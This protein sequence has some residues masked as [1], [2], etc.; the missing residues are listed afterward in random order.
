MWRWLLKRLCVACVVTSLLE[1]CLRCCV[2]QW[3]AKCVSDYDP[4]GFVCWRCWPKGVLRGGELVFDDTG[5]SGAVLRT[6]F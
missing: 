6:C 3:W 1:V 5:L 4:S 2:V